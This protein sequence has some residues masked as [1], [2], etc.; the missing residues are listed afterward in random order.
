MDNEKF[1]RI[2]PFFGV[3]SVMVFLLFMSISTFM[4]SSRAS[5]QQ[6]V[7]ESYAEE[8]M[9]NVTLPP[10]RA[11]QGITV[12]GDLEGRFTVGYKLRPD[13]ACDSEGIKLAIGKIDGLYYV[14]NY[15]TVESTG[16]DRYK[17]YLQLSPLDVQ[18]DIY[19]GNVVLTISEDQ[20]SGV[21]T[22]DLYNNDRSVKSIRISGDWACPL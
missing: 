10:G 12:S 18:G 11:W 22:G 21:V 16:S 1:K 17:G 8:F 9:P 14:F 3:G 19:G 6:N 2:L 13:D 5:R 15:S 7:T 20:R 4:I